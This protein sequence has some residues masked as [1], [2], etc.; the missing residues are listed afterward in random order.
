[1]LHEQATIDYAQLSRPR[2]PRLRSFLIE[3]FATRGP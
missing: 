1:M 2:F 3:W